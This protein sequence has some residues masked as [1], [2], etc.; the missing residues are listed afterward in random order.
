M[1][2]AGSASTFAGCNRVVGES[3]ASWRPLLWFILRTLGRLYL[4]SIACMMFASSEA[5]VTG[6]QTSSGGEAGII[7]LV[8]RH[9]CLLWMF[10]LRDGT[11]PSMIWC[12]LRAR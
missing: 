8:G 11:G 3:T 5:M 2:C 7:L 9:A 6:H 10:L 12:Q 1:D 4:L